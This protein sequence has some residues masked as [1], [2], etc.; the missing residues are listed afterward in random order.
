ML[1]HAVAGAIREG[2]TDKAL[3]RLQHAAN[4]VNGLVCSYLKPC[5][6]YV[7]HL[8][9]DLGGNPLGEG[10]A[11]IVSGTPENFVRVLDDVDHAIR[12]TAAAYDAV[13]SERERGML[14][15]LR[16]EVLDATRC[17][18]MAIPGLVG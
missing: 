14:R 9:P 13:V 5:L 16:E 6:S 7:P 4:E 15:V 11:P 8:D 2:V 3:G 12:R 10:P 18:R 17:A 1:D